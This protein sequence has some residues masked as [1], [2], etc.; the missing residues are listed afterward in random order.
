M[1]AWTAETN[2]RYDSPEWS[3]WQSVDKGKPMGAGRH[4]AN[5]TWTRQFTNGLVIVNPTTGQRKWHLRLKYCTTDHRRPPATV[6]TPAHD[7]TLLIRMP[8]GKRSCAQ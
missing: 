8:A 4:N 1:V 2:G 3:A 7:A 5:G 6:L